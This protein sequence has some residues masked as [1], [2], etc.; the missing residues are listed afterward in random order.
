MTG[1]DVRWEGVSHRQIVA[2]VDRGP[3]AA[4]TEA[5]E[6][7][8]ERVTRA[9]GENAGLADAVLRE[10]DGGWTG[11]AATVTAE[12]LRLLRDFDDA[13]RHHGEMTG[14][15]ASGQS[16][17]S[18]RVR[19]SMPPVADPWPSL[20]PT[21]GPID[22]LNSTVDVDHQLRAAREAE[23]RAR[24][25]MRGYESTTVERVASLPPLSPAPR[26]VLD[27]DEDTIVLVPVEFEP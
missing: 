27:G 2:G 13:M 10:I 8:L 12:T 5:L 24:Q 3:G 23:E 11:D 1:P 7:R 26:V 4:A 17:G 25:V 9:L 22:V 6:A 18:S 21:G 19:A 16:D 15:T 20:F 14:L